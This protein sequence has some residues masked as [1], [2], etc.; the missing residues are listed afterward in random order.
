MNPF[1]I[2][3]VASKKKL[4]IRIPYN[5]GI[6]FV[7]DLASFFLSFFFS[8]SLSLSMVVKPGVSFS[9]SHIYI[10]R[11]FKVPVCL[12]GGWGSGQGSV[13]V[14]GAGDLDQ[15]GSISLTLTCDIDRPSDL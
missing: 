4:L 7:F 2:L 15:E 6:R 10:C 13:R 8:L 3:R 12:T 1:C 11:R 9:I 14:F 5:R